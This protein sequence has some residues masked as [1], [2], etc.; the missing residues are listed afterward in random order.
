MIVRLFALLC[1]GFGAG[2]I[3]A[4]PIYSFGATRPCDTCHANP[5]GSDK[6]TEWK[7]PELKSR[8]CNMSCQSCH[9]NPSGAGLRNGPGRYFAQAALPVYNKQARPYHDL[10][11][12]LS[13]FISRLQAKQTKEADLERKNPTT[14]QA[15]VK[16]E[17]RA[18]KADSEARSGKSFPW[19]YSGDWFSWGHPLNAESVAEQSAYAFRVYRYG[20][21]NA[22]P[23]LTVGGY[24]R[25]ALYNTPGT[26]IAVFPL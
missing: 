1:F 5:F 9:V 12:N 4:L 18:P 8:K 19:F 21:I 26:A 23:F 13:D 24:V 15:T 10:N 16:D 14:T 25:L 2:Q 6:E 11:R 17:A 20:T 22:D 7:N 3:H